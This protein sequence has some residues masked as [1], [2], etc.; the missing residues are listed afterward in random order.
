MPPSSATH[1][2]CNPIAVE[3]D[4]AADLPGSHEYALPSR[5]FQRETDLRHPVRAW[6]AQRYEVVADEIGPAFA[7]AD[8]VAARKG[9]QPTRQHPLT[10]SLQLGLLNFLTHPRSEEEIRNW[11]PTHWTSLRRS[12]I[13][14]LLECEMISIDPETDMWGAELPPQAYEELVT[15]ELKLRD[16]TKALRQATLHHLYGHRA[17][18]AMPA[19][20]VREPWLAQARVHG[21]GLLA[22]GLDGEVRVLVACQRNPPVDAQLSRMAEEKLLADELGMREGE[23]IGGSPRKR[24]C[25]S[26]LRAT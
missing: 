11:A 17:F 25:A 14:P 5:G 18:V 7:V 4:S 9:D 22:V 24:R 13:E 23:W 19:D 6:L 8:L 2:I 15:V 12:A 3:L 20:A 21:I 26:P 10:S 1:E 16:W